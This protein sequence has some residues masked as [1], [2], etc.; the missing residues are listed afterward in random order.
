[1]L[2]FILQILLS[3]SSTLYPSLPKSPPDVE[4]LR[5]YLILPHLHMFEQP[6]YYSTLIEPFG[7][8]IINLDKQASRVLGLYTTLIN[9]LEKNLRY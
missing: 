2:L 3:L 6:K 5:L 9:L 4:A 1:M 8:S 7:H